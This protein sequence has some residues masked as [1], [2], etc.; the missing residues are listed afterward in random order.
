MPFKCQLKWSISKNKRRKCDWYMNV[1]LQPRH[2]VIYFYKFHL[3]KK[4]LVEAFQISSNTFL[5][6]RMHLG[7]NSCKSA[8]RLEQFQLIQSLHDMVTVWDLCRSSLTS[9]ILQ[10]FLNFLSPEIKAIFG[11]HLLQQQ[12]K[13]KLKNVRPVI[14]FVI[15]SPWN[16]LQAKNLNYRT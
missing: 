7:N 2:T 1:L 9:I 8:F 4:N 11:Q 15:F 16:S 5:L 12:Y 13:L 3:K 6:Y 10:D 14:Q